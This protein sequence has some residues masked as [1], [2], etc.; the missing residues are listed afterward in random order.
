M[1]TRPVR[2]VQT[3]APPGLAAVRT[4]SRK[5]QSADGEEILVGIKLAGLGERLQISLS[6]VDFRKRSRKTVHAHRQEHVRPRTVSC[7]IPALEGAL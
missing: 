4:Q 2:T 7:S 6:Q 5:L 1:L 3:Q